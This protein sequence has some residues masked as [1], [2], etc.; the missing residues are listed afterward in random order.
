MNIY[1]MRNFFI[2]LFFLF[3]FPVIQSIN[4]APSVQIVNEPAAAILTTKSN[5]VEKI[6]FDGKW[7]S[8]LE[9]KESSWDIIRSEGID[10]IHLRSAHQG[11]F[12]YILLDVIADKTLDHISDKAL[13][14]IDSKN[15]K[16]SI[17]GYDD[18]CFQAS[19]DAKQGF[20]YQGEDGS[21]LALNS[22]FK[23]I[24]NP[25]GFIG[26]G[27]KSDHN[28][29]YSS[30]PH[31]SYE[32]KIPLELFG[33]SDIYGFYFHAYDASTSQYYS[34]PNQANPSSPFDI[35]SPSSWGILVSPDKSI[36]EFELPFL[37]LILA[38]FLVIYLTRIRI[39]RLE[40]KNN[41]FTKAKNSLTRK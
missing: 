15:D 25:D 26:I 33:R 34:W 5:T 19:L 32:F 1:T 20:V 40:N 13:V 16:T 23:K 8:N 24:L 31:T 10:S 12:I 14:C 39:V 28:D 2:I 29:K 9:W 17:A 18:Y 38:I 30:I 27:S 36:P 22:N 11:D 7:T 4:A 35:P 3:S 37:A 6:I 21:H 41:V